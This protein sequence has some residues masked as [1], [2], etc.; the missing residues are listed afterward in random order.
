MNRLL[1]I[2]KGISEINRNILDNQKMLLGF[3]RSVAP[4]LI[5]DVSPSLESQSSIQN[6]NVN[7]TEE[8]ESLDAEPH[9]PASSGVMRRFGTVLITVRNSPPYTDWSVS[10]YR[11]G[12]LANYAEY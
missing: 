12:T 8:Y 1:L 5:S 3:F 10:N 7:D 9:C 4:Y 6:R 2:G 11:I